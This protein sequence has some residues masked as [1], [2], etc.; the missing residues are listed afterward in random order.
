MIDQEGRER[1]AAFERG[2]EATARIERAVADLDAAQAAA[3]FWLRWWPFLTRAAWA[4]ETRRRA[5]VRE[6]DALRAELRRDE[7]QGQHG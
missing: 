7:E 2:R 5:L 6:I 1:R 4:R 3:P